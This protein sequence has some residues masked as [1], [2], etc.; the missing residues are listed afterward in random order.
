LG[1]HS[2]LAK[3]LHWAFTLKA[4][5]ARNNVII[6]SILIPFIVIFFIERMNF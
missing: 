2:F 4:V 3:A 6:D 5:I 1:R